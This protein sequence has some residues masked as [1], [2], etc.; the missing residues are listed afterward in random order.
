M[1]WKSKKSFS[2]F[3]SKSLNDVSADELQ[4]IRQMRYEELQKIKTQLRE[5]DQQWQ[6]DLAKWKSRRRSH[7]S[8]LQRKKEEREEIERRSSESSERR[9][10]TLR[11]M[12]RDR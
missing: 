1:V 10:K 11:E 2:T 12:Q 7:T 9:S 5:Q 8:D 3:R 6:D 4:T